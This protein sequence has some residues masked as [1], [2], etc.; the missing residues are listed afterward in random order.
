MLNLLDFGRR[1]HKRP[2]EPTESQL[3]VQAKVIA[4]L[5]KYGS[6]TAW[7]AQQMG[8]TSAAKI[9]TRLRQKGYLYAAENPKG[10][11]NEPNSR[12]QGTHKVHLWTG[13]E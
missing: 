11:R 5:K 10:F 1:T 2:F 12:G 9:F 4:H 8:T 7:E 3:T 13:K 6:I